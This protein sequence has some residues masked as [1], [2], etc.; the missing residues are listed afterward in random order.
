MRDCHIRDG[1][2]GEFETG[3]LL[4][5]LHD[6]LWVMRGPG[7]D[8]QSIGDDGTPRRGD[9]QKTVRPT[10]SAQKNVVTWSLQ[11]FVPTGQEEYID[12][13]ARQLNLSNL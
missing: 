6:D 4:C 2:C 5:R 7:E 3:L 1:L 11:K 12:H 13:P 9:R 10:L 8:C